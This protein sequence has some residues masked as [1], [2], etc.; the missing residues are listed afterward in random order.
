MLY[1][2]GDAI[3]VFNTYYSYGKN[4]HRVKT[5]LLYY[6]LQHFS[7]LRIIRKFYVSYPFQ[8]EKMANY[9]STH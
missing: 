1:K 6:K 4:C 8:N 5:Y 9:K 7:R 3:P 2:N